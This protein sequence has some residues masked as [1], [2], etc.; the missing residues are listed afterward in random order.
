MLA[1]VPIVRRLRAGSA[2][3]KDTPFACRPCHPVGYEGNYQGRSNPIHF[4][5]D[6]HT[7]GCGRSIALMRDGGLPALPTPRRA[8][9]RAHSIHSGPAGAAVSR[10]E[11]MSS[12]WGCGV[13]CKHGARPRLSRSRARIDT[14][15]IATRFA[16]IQRRT[17]ATWRPTGGIKRSSVSGR[18]PGLVARDRPLGGAY[19]VRRTERLEPALDHVEQALTDRGGLGVGERAQRTV[20][21]EH[22]EAVDRGPGQVLGARAPLGRQGTRRDEAV[23]RDRQQTR[24]GSGRSPPVRSRRSPPARAR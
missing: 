5:G 16:P 6:T 21:R 17:R 8:L 20:E 9:S 7:A 2:T 18:H 19:T 1:I 11:E 22:G 13:P 14:A 24:R 15:Q 4:S 3:R 10:G 23:Q 12:V